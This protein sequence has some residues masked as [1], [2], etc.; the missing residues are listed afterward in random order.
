MGLSK[1]IAS[2]FLVPSSWNCL[3]KSCHINVHN[4]QFAGLQRTCRNKPLENRLS[5]P[6][7]I[8][9]FFF[10]W[11]LVS[12]VKITLLTKRFL[13]V[14]VPAPHQSCR[15]SH[16]LLSRMVGLH[17]VD[18]QWLF[19]RLRFLRCCL[20]AKCPVFVEN[21]SYWKPL[22]DKTVCDVTWPCIW[23]TS[24]VFIHAFVSL[25]LT[26]QTGSHEEGAN[27]EL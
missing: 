25:L 19:V 14:W 8:S 12:L 21:R 17:S 5:C 9:C 24:V 13:L 23:H 2:L 1:I 20:F 11:L 10:V 26:N 15:D 18:A 27:Q 3:W 7:S 4:V 16:G 6:V 22:K